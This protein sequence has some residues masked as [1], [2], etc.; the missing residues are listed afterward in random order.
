MLS[1]AFV[2]SKQQQESTHTAKEI[3]SIINIDS[4]AFTLIDSVEIAD[5]R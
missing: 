2:R 1:G 5:Y 4:V 3:Q